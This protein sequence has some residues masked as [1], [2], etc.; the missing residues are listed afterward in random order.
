[1]VQAEGA[2]LQ[3]LKAKALA[4]VAIDVHGH[5]SEGQ[6]PGILHPEALAYGEEWLVGAKAY[7]TH[8]HTHTHTFMISLAL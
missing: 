8:T 1:M 5:D 3:H 6:L 2:T 4:L 7:H